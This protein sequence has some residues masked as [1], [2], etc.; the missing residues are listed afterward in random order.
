MREAAG[1]RWGDLSFLLGGYTSR[2]DR[3]SGKRVDGPKEKWTPNLRIVA[4]TIDFLK[5]T[6]RMEAYPRDLDQGETSPTSNGG[7]GTI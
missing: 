1:G 3:R 6:R 4:K 7:D 5:Q 2:L